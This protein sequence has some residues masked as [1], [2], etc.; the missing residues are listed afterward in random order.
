MDFEYTKEDVD[1]FWK[2]VKKLY[3]KDGTDACWLWKGHTNTFGYGLFNNSSNTMLA[4]RFSFQLHGKTIPHKW[5]INHKCE[6]RNC[7]NPYH[8]NKMT[9]GKNLS[10]RGTIQSLD[11]ED[12]SESVKIVSPMNNFQQCV[13][14]LECEFSNIGDVTPEYVHEMG[15]LDFYSNDDD[16][17]KN[18]SEKLVQVLGGHN[19]A[20]LIEFKRNTAPQHYRL[21]HELSGEEI[22]FNKLKRKYFW[23]LDY[24]LDEYNIQWKELWAYYVFDRKYLRN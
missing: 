23:L 14:K 9:Q 5:V 15:D 2:N 17:I 20:K 1:N 13:R 21:S 7:V 3:N 12:E 18:N 19:V 22:L 8:L 16:V 10:L 6:T 11:D 4:H 24:I